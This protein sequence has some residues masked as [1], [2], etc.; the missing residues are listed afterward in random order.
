MYREIFS[1]VGK[2]KKQAILSPVS[3][4]G[5]VAME[6]LIPMVMAKIIDDGIKQGRI[7][8]VAGMGMLMAGMAVVSLFFGA[9]A[10]RLSAVAAMGFAKNLRSALFRKVQDFSFA[11]VD[12]FSTASLTTR[13]TTDVTNLQNAFMMFLRMA[14]RAPI[15]LICALIAALEMNSRLSVVFLCAVPVLAGVVIFI[16]TKAHPRFKAMLANYDSMNASVQENLIGIRTVKAF[17]R[18]EYEKKKFTDNTE[19]VRKAQVNAEK[20]IVM[21]MPIMQFVM[22]ASIISI[23]FFGGRMAVGGEMDTGELSSFISY[24]GQVL[25]SLMMLSFMF[26]M[27]V[28]SRASLQRVYEVLTEE[29]DIVSPENPE[30]TVADGSVSFRNV[31]FSYFKDMNNLALSGINADIRS[32]ETIGVI[33]GTGSSK[34]SLVQLIPRLYDATEGEVFVGGKNVKEYS[35]DVLRDNVAMVLQKNVLFSGTIRD[36]L[37]WGNAEATDAEIEAACRSACAHD[38]IMDFPKGYDTD[39]GQGGVNVSGGQKQRICIA[40]ALLKNPKIIILDDSTSAVDTATDSN[41]RKAFR[42]NL[43]DTTTFIIAQRI[44]SVQDADRIIVMDEGKISDIGTHE[45]LLERS[46][47]YREV[48]ESQ[49]KGADE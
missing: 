23:L 10:G 5:E 34:T 15:M 41:I 4:I 3:I 42:E 28:L 2:Y 38:F 1:Y 43:A 27:F 40:R 49:Q 14:F 48:Y 37:R 36:N 35:L 9:I 13:L 20:L 45:E 24:V 39:L 30:V 22:Y 17:V 12:K 21:T 6:V 31:S 16:M 46:S 25:M 18:E 47:I 32:G 8:Y 33:G 26:V 44:S 7:G 19:A 11:N 29:P